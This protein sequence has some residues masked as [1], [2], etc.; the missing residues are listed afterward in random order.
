MKA[1]KDIT[2]Q[3][4]QAQAGG[5]TAL[6]AGGN[7]RLLADKTTNSTHVEANSRTSS[8]SNSREEDQLYLSTLG[9]DKG[10]TIIAGKELLAEGGYCFFYRGGHGFWELVVC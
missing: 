1:G 3:G 2:L 10:V 4:S 5:Q 8:V 6:Q 9:G 7:I